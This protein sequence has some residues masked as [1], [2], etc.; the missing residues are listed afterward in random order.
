MGLVDCWPMQCPPMLPTGTASCKN[1]TTF[2][3]YNSPIADCCAPRCDSK[4]SFLASS[5]TP[6]TTTVTGSVDPC[7]QQLKESHH[8]NVNGNKDADE[9]KNNNQ[10]LPLAA[11][12]LCFYEGRA[13]QS[14]ARWDD[15]VDMCTSCDCKVKKTQFII[16]S[17]VKYNMTC[18]SY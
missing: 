13:Y 11:S 17:Y 12:K 15:P 14:G 18:F 1:S 5:V 8:E 16:F 4:A 3:D 7:L 2:A 6:T 9:N 10:T